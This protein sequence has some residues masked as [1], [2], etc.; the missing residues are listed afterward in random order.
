[1]KS[2]NPSGHPVARRLWCYHNLYFNETSW[3]LHS[4]LIAVV[5][6][7]FELVCYRFNDFEKI[8]S[9]LTE[10]WTGREVVGGGGGGGGG[11]GRHFR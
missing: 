2:S 5:R 7:N 10:H 1:M 11:G 9:Q 6:P 8:I 4:N 3:F